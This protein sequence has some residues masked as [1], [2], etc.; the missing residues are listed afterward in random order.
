MSPSIEFGQVTKI[1]NGVD[2]SSSYYGHEEY[3]A[4]VYCW[5]IKLDSDE[6][7]VEKRIKCHSNIVVVHDDLK[8]DLMMRRLSLG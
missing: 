2:E 3:C 8:G 4:H 7:V 6:T 5:N 1:V